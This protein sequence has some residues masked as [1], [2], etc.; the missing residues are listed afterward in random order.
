MPSNLR[1]DSNGDFLWIF[2]NVSTP[3]AAV[4]TIQRKSFLLRD[5]LLCCI[6]C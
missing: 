5:A 4:Q 3:A 6:Y 2:R 1:D